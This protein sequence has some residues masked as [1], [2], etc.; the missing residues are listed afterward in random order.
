MRTSAKHIALTGVA[1]AVLVTG[2]TAGTIAKVNAASAAGGQSTASARQDS[3]DARRAAP[4]DS[5]E[6]LL[7]GTTTASYF[8]DDGSGIRGDTG[9]PA[10]GKPMQKG[11]FASPSW[12]MLTKV[13]VTYGGRSVTGFIGDRGPGEPS[14][15]GIMLDLDTHSF[16]YL[17]DGG[18]PKDDYHAGGGTGHLKGVKYEVLEW[19]PGPGE[20]GAPKPF[21]S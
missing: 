15:R 3:A 2:V 18:K 4:G 20:K 1:G 21:G 12:P 14:H 16:R 6:V 11:M 10:S 9:A 5:G 19:G 13:R 8:W 17:L 7:T